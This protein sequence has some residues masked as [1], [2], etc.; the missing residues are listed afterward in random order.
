VSINPIE[1]LAVTVNHA[2][3]DDLANTNVASTEPHSK[4]ASHTTAQTPRR[5]TPAAAAVALAS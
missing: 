2:I 1:V 4:N 5:E 3:Q